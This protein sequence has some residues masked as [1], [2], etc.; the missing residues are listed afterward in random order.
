PGYG[1]TVEQIGSGVSV[2]LED[3]GDLARSL[4]GLLK[5]PEQRAR[6]GRRGREAVVAGHTWSARAA[7]LD[8][9]LREAAGR[10]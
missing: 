3:P 4:V 2:R 8:A 5:D 9:V 7:Q 1:E 6:M 10:T